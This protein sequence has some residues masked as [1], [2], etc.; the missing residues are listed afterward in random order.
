MI[1]RRNFLGAS[2]AALVTTLGRPSAGSPGIPLA[3]ADTPGTLTVALA[4]ETGSDT[5]YAYVT[6]QDPS[7]GN[8]W[9]LLR[10][11]G[12]TVYHPPSPPAP[13]APLDV[14]CAIALGGTGGPARTIAVPHLVG[15]R[16]WFSVGK[17]LTF[18][19]NPG[20][21]IVM[22]SATNRSDP[23]IDVSWGFCELTYDTTQLYA[24]ISFVDLVSLPIALSLETPQGTQVVRGLPRGGLDTVCGALRAQGGDWA[25]LVVNG[26]DDRPL[27]ALSP[28][29]AIAADGS[30]FAGYLDGYIDAVW[31]H[32]AGTDLVIDTQSGWGTVTGRVSNGTLT[33]PGVGGF[34][35]P[36]TPAVFSCSQP[37]FT[38]G[39]DE[40]GNL[41][42]RLAAA[43]NR[44]TLLVNARQP[45]G[46][47]PATFYREPATNH[48]ARIVHA[49]LPDGLGYAFPYDDVH[50]DG[51]DF[52]GK[53]QSAQPGTLTVTV[54]S[55]H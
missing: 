50:P 5:V 51:V 8:A 45:T 14:D 12:R 6:G 25:K 1:T 42:A 9:M 24:N 29:Q 21:A 28:N 55:P 38:T 31:Q 33:F 19:V 54:G 44:T 20:P 53:V 46:E 22:P 3:A 17:K 49:T 48:Y 32:Y 36:S 2:A 4:N 37:P 23:N 43:F 26:P 47:N 27:R 7:N 40:M 39:N 10:A 18:L 13:G 34:A 11:D 15:G 35:K 16:I 52:E 30:L 41:S